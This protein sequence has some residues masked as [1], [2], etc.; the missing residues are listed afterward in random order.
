[1]GQLHLDHGR[2]GLHAPGDELGG[3]WDDSKEGKGDGMGGKGEEGEV[4]EGKGLGR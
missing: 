2:Q 3:I 1:M 4:K